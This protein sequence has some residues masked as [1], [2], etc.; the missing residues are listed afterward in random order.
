VQGSSSPEIATLFG[1]SASRAVVSV[2]AGDRSALLQ[3]AADAG[4]PA[5]LI[6]KTGGARI[7]V[8]VDGRAAI[9]IARDE[10]ER[11]WSTAIARHFQ[12]RAA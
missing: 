2:A 11:M 12:G 9:D 5:K 7:V 10:A 1:E 3:M 6:G 4:V 8:R